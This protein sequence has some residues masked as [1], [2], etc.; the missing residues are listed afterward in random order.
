MEQR[1]IFTTTISQNFLDD[2]IEGISFLPNIQRIIA[3]VH[4]LIFNCS[5]P[6]QKTSDPL[7]STDLENA[8][9]DVV[10]HVQ[11]QV[12][13][14]EIS[15]IEKGKVLL[16]AMKTLSPFLDPRGIL[17]VGG[18]FLIQVIPMTKDSLYFSQANIDSRLFSSKLRIYAT[19]ILAYSCFIS[20]PKILDT[21]CQKGYLKGAAHEET[22]HWH[23][24]PPS[25]PHFG[26]LWEA[27]VKS[28]KTHFSRVIGEQI[29]T[30]EE[31]NTLLVQVEAELNSHPLCPIS[32]DPN[33]F[34]VLMPGHFLT[35]E[36]L[37]SLPENDFKKFKRL[38]CWELTQ[39]L[40]QSIWSHWS[41]EYLHTLHQRKWLDP[42][43]QITPGTVVL[44]KAESLP[45][46]RWEIRRVA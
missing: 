44:I 1:L 45:P 10:K 20:F 21:F 30:Y 15:R 33:D 22:L 40:Y 37:N 38:S 5:H 3:L 8:L 12:F 31:L 14:E 2:L 17:R 46:L 41:R 11:Q 27:G 13:A 4:R 18:D 36:L 23:L 9:L 6:S 29:L 7:T 26:G 43:F 16:K 39:R 28:V 19:Y 25:A 34:S 32:T 35:M 42:S 24:N